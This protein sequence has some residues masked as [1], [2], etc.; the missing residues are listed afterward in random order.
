[1]AGP[2]LCEHSVS[3]ASHPQLI[4]LSQLHTSR[5]FSTPTREI[6]QV[7]GLMGH[8]LFF[9]IQHVDN[10]RATFHFLCI[11]ILCHHCPSN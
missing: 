2:S 8:A 7:L 10:M 1:M 4:T 5:V 6:L 11:S 3:P 9:G